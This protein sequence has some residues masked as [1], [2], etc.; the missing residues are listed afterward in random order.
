[1]SKVYCS[2]CGAEVVLPE[3]SIVG[4]GM[5]ISEKSKGD[6]VIP[7]KKNNTVDSKVNTNNGGNNMNK[8]FTM[9]ELVATVAAVMGQMNVNQ[10]A[11]EVAQTTEVKT[12]EI[13]STTVKG[14][15]GQNSKYYG[16]VMADG[17]I[18]NPYLDRRFLPAQYLSMIK[19]EYNYSA[20][21]AI[22]NNYSYMYSIEWVVKE[23]D[24]L[25]FLEKADKVAFE[26]R[27]VFLKPEDV[28]FIVRDYVCSLIGLVERRL[29]LGD[30]RKEKKTGDVYLKFKGYKEIYAGRE[31][32]DIENHKVVKRVAKSEELKRTINKFSDLS[33][34]LWELA[35]QSGYN[36]NG[37]YK[38]MN[39]LLQS[40][41]FIQL[42][43]DTKKSPAF[44]DRFM[45]QGAYYTLR[46]LVLFEGYKLKSYNGG[47]ACEL[48]R[49][50]AGLE[51][52]KLHAILKE[53][54]DD[55]A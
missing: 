35:K 52:Y 44:I 40:V 29:K 49:S 30:Y 17:H 48:L 54:L 4:I 21:T 9:E 55:N 45:A 1:M 33:G 24:K 20:Y 34:E 27:R 19:N 41:R 16:K 6:Y 2:N 36:N 42:P 23:V 11:Q 13:G 8:N 15:W 22:K 53:C 18:F 7:T 12:K 3:K 31:V 51:G 50:Y 46:N 43:Y 47:Q 32:E 26:E 14:K 10:P 38:K 25:A 28:F 37:I 39:H 5:T